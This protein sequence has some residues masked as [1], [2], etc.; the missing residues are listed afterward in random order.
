MLRRSLLSILQF[1][2]KPMKDLE[3]QISRVCSLFGDIGV[4]KLKSWLLI[5]YLIKVVKEIK[6]HEELDFQTG[7]LILEVEQWN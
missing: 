3:P 1:P 4:M 2:T 7:V 5:F 6:N